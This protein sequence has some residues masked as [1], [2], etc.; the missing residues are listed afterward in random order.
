MREF[1]WIWQPCEPPREA[2]S[3]EKPALGELPKAGLAD[4]G[5]LSRERT[6][7]PLAATLLTAPVADAIRKQRQECAEAR[8]AAASSA[9]SNVDREAIAARARDEK[10]LAT[11]SATSRSLMLFSWESHRRTSN[12][13]ASSML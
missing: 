6:R 3:K 4:F 1:R 7:M 13:A 9:W 12:A 5:L 11:C 10:S 8:R 2:E